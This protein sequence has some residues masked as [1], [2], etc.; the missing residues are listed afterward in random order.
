MRNAHIERSSRS[1]NS[2]TIH[3]VIC[4]AGGICCLLPLLLCPNSKMELTPLRTAILSQ[5]NRDLSV[6]AL[7]L[8]IPLIMDLITELAYSTWIRGKDDDVKIRVKPSFL[9]SIERS[10]ALFGTAVV[11]MTAFLPAHTHNLAY[12]HACCERCQLV[13][14]GG[15]VMISLCRYND[16]Y[17]TIPRTYLALILLT[18]GTIILAFTGNISD[19]DT[20]R[21]AAYIISY[22]GY[23]TILAS[24]VIFFWCSCLWLSHVIPI[25]SPESFGF[26]TTT[27]SSKTSKTSKKVH[28]KNQKNNNNAAVSSTFSTSSEHL[29]FPA[30][31]VSVSMTTIAMLIMI[32][33]MYPS[34]A[35]YDERA[36]FLHNFSFLLYIAIVS[37]VSIRM[38]KFEVVQGLV[39]TYI[40]TFIRTYIYAYVNT[41]IL[42]YIYAYIHYLRKYIHCCVHSC[43][44][45]HVY[46]Y[47]Y[48]HAYIRAYVCMC[49]CDFCIIWITQC[50]LHCAT[51]H[52][53]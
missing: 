39:S 28:K 32:S 22:F 42:A 43:T 47:I 49:V 46:T 23:S 21:G 25:I 18:I 50:L 10:A 51:L 37:Y 16:K 9:N 8:I 19:T 44:H 15:A 26:S 40:H 24:A 1:E 35:S 38:M 6:A 48:V 52:N 13:M 11:P 3:F 20:A 45:I 2:N 30:L 41:Y 5:S 29:T 33:A 12:I 31:Y 27:N 36:I 34:V 7:S 4:F 14:I 17:W 53:E